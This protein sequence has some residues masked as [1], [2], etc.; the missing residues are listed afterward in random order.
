M[1]NNPEWLNPRS[2]AIPIMRDAQGIKVVLVTS[3]PNGNNWIFPKGQVEMG[4]AA[5]LSAAK[6]A[7]EEAGVIGQV[8]PEVF[9]QYQ[10]KKW[11]GSMTVRV[12]LL[13]VTE[14][15]SSWHEMHQRGRKILPLDDAINLIHAPQ[16]QSLIKLMQQLKNK[17]I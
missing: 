8:N 2:A 17:A 13:E 7:L 12:Y 15:L 1:A 6:E 11:G 3:K 10:H 14:V 9:D 16:K 5:H 4:M